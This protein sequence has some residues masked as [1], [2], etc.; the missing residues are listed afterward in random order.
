LHGRQTTDIKHNACPNFHWESQNL[1]TRGFW[2]SSFLCYFTNGQTTTGTNH[3]PYFWMFSSFF[4]AEVR[5]SFKRLYHSRVCVVLMASSPNTYF[6]ISK[7]SEN[8]FS[9][10]Q[11]NFTQKCC[12]W[13][14]PILNSWK[15]HRANKTHV[16]SNRHSTMTKQTRTIRFVVIA[17][18]NPLQWSATSGISLHLGV[19]TIIQKF[20]N[21][22]DWLSILHELRRQTTPVY[23]SLSS[24]FWPQFGI[25]G[26]NIRSCILFR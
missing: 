6:N 11:P 21:S 8:V 25:S 17:Y 20:G 12:S 16:H 3:F 19:G 4:Y 15:I 14:S 18:G 10:L 5:P 7:V 9:T 23:Y 13:K 24:S 2:S 22:M 26:I 1:M